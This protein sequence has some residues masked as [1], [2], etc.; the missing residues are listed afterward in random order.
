MGHGIFLH[1]DADPVP[2][3]RV[4]SAYA[5]EISIVPHDHADDSA[6]IFEM[7]AGMH[8]TKEEQKLLDKQLSYHP[9]RRYSL[10]LDALKKGN[11]TRFIN[12]SETP[13]VVAHLVRI[14]ANDFG[15]ETSPMQIVYFAKKTILPGEQLLVCYE[16]GE[17]TYWG[18]LKVKPVPVTPRTFH[19]N[20]SLEIHSKAPSCV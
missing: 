7:I 3:G 8:L 9:K 4:I 16:D 20:G 18:A 5:G 14:P 15:L 12:H 13:N 2:K 17:G 11:F 6:Y 1:P 10:N 19:L